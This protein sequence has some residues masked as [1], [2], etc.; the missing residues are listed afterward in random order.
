M[1]SQDDHGHVGGDQFEQQLSDTSDT[2][3]TSEASSTEVKDAA[4]DASDVD[5]VNRTATLISLFIALACI[6]GLVALAVSNTT[7]N[8][9]ATDATSSSASIAPSDSASLDSGVAMSKEEVAALAGTGSLS[10]VRLPLLKDEGATAHEIELKDMADV[11]GGKPTV[12]NVWAWNC[13]PCRQELPL[14]QQWAKANPDVQ[15][16]TVHAAREAERGQS[17]LQE[18]GV[19]LPTYS[20]TVDAVGSALN[21]P[22][23]VPITVVFAQDGS[24]LTMHPGEFTSSQQ[25][26]DVVR[27]ALK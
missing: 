25:I 20:D 12:V 14:L 2:S 4:A 27:G 13:A 15:V 1:I 21:L 17:F 9:D 8:N 7:G 26:S 22:R 5:G 3:E 11:L 24:M 23:A 10:G 6:I 19:S 18:I 16:V